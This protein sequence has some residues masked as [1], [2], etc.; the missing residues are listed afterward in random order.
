MINDYIKFKYIIWND[1]KY[2]QIISLSFIQIDNN[3]RLYFSPLDG[4]GNGFEAFI[5]ECVGYEM[6]GEDF[7]QESYCEILLEVI[8][9][10][11]G[12]RHVYFMP[13][14][15]CGYANYPNIKSWSQIINLL[16]DLELKYCKYPHHK[17]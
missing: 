5:I 2:E 10:F 4:E 1:K 6:P 3:I 8:A 14:E 11:D 16:S 13:G 17:F 15:N 9:F 7:G 12:L